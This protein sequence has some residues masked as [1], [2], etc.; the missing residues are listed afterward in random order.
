LVSGERRLL[1][2]HMLVIAGG[3]SYGDDLGAGVL[4]ALD[5]RERIAGVEA[6]VT[7]GRP[8]LGIC[9]GFQTLVKAGLIPGPA[10]AGER[11]VTLTY[12]EGGQFECRWVY[13]Q[14]QA[15]SP[16]LFTEGLTELIHCPVAHGEGRVMT[17]DDAT[18]KRL[19]DEGLVA[20][21]YVDALGRPQGYPV[22]PNGSVLNIAGLCN[23]EGNVF[24][25]MPHPENHIFPW[26]NP[27]ATRGARG[28]DGLRLFKNGIRF[29]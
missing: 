5:L 10:W 13:L 7:S 19:W 11:S 26:Q 23:P 4:W 16:C 14:P 12:N 22:N 24:G 3:F 9:N 25:L 20:L 18:A 21:A 8:V 15:A 27:R 6:F 17:S 1:D 29:A 2:Y 28:M